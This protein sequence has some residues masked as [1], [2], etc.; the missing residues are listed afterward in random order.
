MRSPGGEL[1]SLPFVKYVPIFFKESLQNL[2]LGRNTANV[3]GG[4][5][6]RAP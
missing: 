3:V 5:Y 4:N 2:A 6:L 1:A